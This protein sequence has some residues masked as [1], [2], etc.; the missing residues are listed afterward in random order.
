M[1]VEI[2]L[3]ENA[4]AGILLTVTALL[5]G[6][7]K[8]AVF[9]VFP[10]DSA[11]R[12]S[13]D[14]NHA[15]FHA[16]FSAALLT[17]GAFPCSAAAQL[18]LTCWP[19][20]YDGLLSAAA[21]PLTMTV[22]V[23]ENAWAFLPDLAP[24]PPALAAQ[25]VRCLGELGPVRR[26]ILPLAGISPHP[27]EPRI[28]VIYDMAYEGAAETWVRQ[29]MV[30]CPGLMVDSCPGLNFRGAATRAQR[31]TEVFRRSRAVLYL[32]H[33]PRDGGWSVD[34][35]S[36]DSLPI[37]EVLYAVHPE[38]GLKGG[39]ML[40]VPEIIVVTGCH[41]AG[42][43]G[44]KDP[45]PG[46]VA[47]KFLQCGVRFYVGTWGRI[48]PDGG[49]LGVAMD[50]LARFF[51]AWEK[52]PT[53]VV[54]HVYEAKQAAEFPLVGHLFQ[55]YTTAAA[56]GDEASARD[57]P[58][59]AVAAEVQQAVAALPGPAMGGYGNLE[60]LW[61][62]RHAAVY[63]AVERETGEPV[64]LQFPSDGFQILPGF[65]KALT[66]AVDRLAPLRGRPGH[67]VPRR[68]EPFSPADSP[69][70]SER[71]VI[72]LVYENA[73]SVIPWELAADGPMRTQAVLHSG[74]MLSSALEVL[75]RENLAHGNVSPASLVRVSSRS[76]DTVC[77]KDHWVGLV[78]PGRC[79]APPYSPPEGSAA[80]G[81]PEVQRADCWA[82][83]ALLFEMAFGCPPYGRDALPAQQVPPELPER[84]GD[85]VPPVL[86]KTIRDCLA[87]A[88]G[89][90]PA[91][92]QVASRFRRM[93]AGGG[94]YLDAFLEEL[95]AAVIAGYRLLWVP[96]VD[97]EEVRQAVRRLVEGDNPRRFALRTAEHGKPMLDDYGTVAVEWPVV[98][99]NDDIPAEAYFAH[100]VLQHMI[101]LAHGVDQR[102]PLCLLNG[103][104]WF[105]YGDTCHS[106]LKQIHSRPEEMP[107][108]IVGGEMPELPREVGRFFK[109]L[110]LLAPDPADLM[111]MIAR[112]PEEEG[113]PEIEVPVSM[114]VYLASQFHP[115][116]RRDVVYA[117]RT[118]ALAHGAIDERVLDAVRAYQALRIGRLGT[119]RLLS[120]ADLPGEGEV[121]VPPERE[122]WLEQWMDG[123]RRYHDGSAPPPASMSLL[124]TGSDR[125]AK[126]R[127]AMEIAR[128]LD[129]PL[130]ELDTASCLSSRLGQSEA[131]MR[132]LLA[133]ARAIGAV[134]L[135]R[136]IGGFSPGSRRLPAPDGD[137]ER[138]DSI[139]SVMARMSGV[140]LRW[141][142]DC[143]TSARPV[144]LATAPS[145]IGL[146]A[147]WRRRFP[148]E[149]AVFPP[150]GEYRSAVFRAA[151]RRHRLTALSG[152][153]GFVD[154]LASATD[155]DNA[156]PVP[157]PEAR[158]AAPGSALRRQ[159]ERIGGEDDIEGWIVGNLRLG[160]DRG[161]PRSRSFWEAA[162]R[163][164][165][166]D[167]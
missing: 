48:F 167:G 98:A 149:L 85:P 128:R 25:G 79:A 14:K 78:M 23:S 101:H 166:D 106:Y 82:L 16:A 81:L 160:A 92:R 164:P 24:P 129:R 137:K 19:A 144:I 94:A 111:E 2:T 53:R 87:P 100:D 75:H 52:A 89:L 143:G 134:I 62:D 20:G 43:A 18:A 165:G 45:G 22:N 64:L 39:G 35:G 31:L 74:A 58:R 50:L 99:P 154:W 76:G 44:A 157:V 86:I 108:L 95:E 8:G 40:P 121:A 51:C 80:P 96:T 84:P 38:L 77:L 69:V 91:A 29:M 140:V 1:H 49:S 72:G 123:I 60:R 107:V 55:V 5:G 109:E 120:R 90:R 30:E 104:R 142:D 136:D 28:S 21:P 13:V 41:A 112:F 61:E 138:S 88:P 110:P 17:G 102:R 116:A 66:E 12:N 152:S 133:D 125:D 26:S 118:S 135:F 114:A 141:M 70:D 59:G 4:R 105:D 68:V 42:N 156:G 117:L 9:R 155:P 63:R 93:L 67:L 148:Q 146:D 162:V 153:P 73:E 161:D 124:L 36:G 145:R 158:F 33:L 10:P 131:N 71:E 37:D 47:G 113:F 3:T 103:W 27:S 126:G 119:A 11:D 132:Y 122:Q 147:Q 151:L 6:G 127:I 139:G 130:V 97:F 54:E 15:A 46:F 115:C 65:R 34:S 159:R 163:A 83:G 150:R 56:T 57:L 7:G 32:G